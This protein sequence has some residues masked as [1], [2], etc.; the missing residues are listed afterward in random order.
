ML[1]VN[2]LK[3]INDTFGHQEGDIFLKH[4]SQILT[5]LSRQGDILARI[6][7]DEFAI[8][9][10]STTSEEAHSFCERIKKVCQQ[11]KIEPTYLRLNVSLGHATQEGEY[12]NIKLSL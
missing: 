3:V 12:K 4:L 10:P 5:S 1:D 2:G 8:L 6:G 11:D 7:G 9:L